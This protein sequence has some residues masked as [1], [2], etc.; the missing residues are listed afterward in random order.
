M[1]RRTTML[2][3]VL[4]ALVACTGT[5]TTEPPTATAIP[6]ST[7]QPQPTSQPSPT[8]GPTRTRPPAT[9]TPEVWPTLSP[10]TRTGI[11]I[12]DAVIEA[13]LAQDADKVLSL[14]HYTTIGCTHSDGLGGPPKCKDDEP[15]GTM[16]EA[17]PILGSEGSFV[18][19]EEMQFQFPPKGYGLFG[20][21]KVVPGAYIPDY[22]P[23]GDY[24][25]VFITDS[26]NWTYAAFVDETGIVRAIYHPT[27][28]NIFN[29]GVGEF[30]VPP[31]ITPTPV[32]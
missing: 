32:S 28:D 2:G 11:S 21:Y 22:G 19:K 31:L 4:V 9:P 30:I 12:V 27:L 26:P 20:V 6:S 13:T 25:I 23:E 1:I 5:T 17:F 14:I 18:R 7:P 8:R 29:P 10:D 16:I 3:I 24:G 15:E